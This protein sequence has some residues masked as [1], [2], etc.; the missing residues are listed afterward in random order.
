MTGSLTKTGKF[1]HRQTHTEKWCEDPKGQ[2]H[3]KT[4]DCS[5]G[6]M[7]QGTPWATWDY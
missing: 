3:E 4:E 1:G 2:C 6:S 5:D 7:S